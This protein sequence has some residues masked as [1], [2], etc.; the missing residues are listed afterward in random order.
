MSAAEAAVVPRYADDRYGPLTIRS[1]VRGT[2]F[3]TKGPTVSTWDKEPLRGSKVPRARTEPLCVFQAE[4]FDTPTK[5]I[6]QGWVPT[7]MVP[8]LFV[9][10]I[11]EF[12]LWEVGWDGEDAARIEPLAAINA[13]RLATKMLDVADEPIAAPSPDGSLALLWDFA[14]GSSIEVYIDSDEEE[15]TWA[16]LITVDR[17]VEELTLDG[18]PALRSVL[19]ERAEAAATRA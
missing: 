10:R 6:H 18:A 3:I 16:G 4:P 19:R 5:V 9:S 15:P 11:L 1:G 17:P 2:C 14:D 8:P 12:A 7:N 13:I